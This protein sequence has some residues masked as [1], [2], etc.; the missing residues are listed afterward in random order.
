MVSEP[1]Y[2]FGNHPSMEVRSLEWSS[3]QQRIVPDSVS[4]P[5]L[6]RGAFV[7]GVP[8]PG[9]PEYQASYEEK[10]TEIRSNWKIVTDPESEGD[11]TFEMTIAN[12]DALGNEEGAILRIS[13]HSV[14][15]NPIEAVE[16]ADDAVNNPGRTIIHLL[17]PGHGGST[18]LSNEELVEASEN[19]R[20]LSV[21]P[22]P[23][24]DAFPSIKSIA[25][26]LD[27]IRGN[28][29][30][31]S[32]S[33][34]AAHFT[35]AAMSTLPDVQRA[36][37]INPTNISDIYSQLTEILTLRRD[38][39][40]K[41]GYNP[42]LAAEIA[43]SQKY[44]DLSTDPLAVTQARTEEAVRIMGED[45]A[46]YAAEQR[47]AS[48]H[49]LK[50]RG[51]GDIFK[52]GLDRGSAAVHHTLAALRQNPRAK[53]TYIFPEFSANYADGIEISRFMEAIYDQDDVGHIDMDV[54]GLI[55]P[56]GQFWP[57]YHPMG[58]LALHREAFSR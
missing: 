2:E 46:E 38:Y 11:R 30:G 12:A 39:S 18:G 33:G 7:E 44:A 27:Q 19:G 17:Q 29:T 26:I 45:F 1:N 42:R 54:R 23:D 57:R 49:I 6:D 13:K 10:L 28:I 22:G 24:Y 21:F 34:E 41:Q 37:L 8:E 40:Y 52:K 36:E 50:A 43:K 16:L 32:S 3:G 15:D 25:R 14:A 5:L 31:L 48:A 20:L 35:S 58:R 47:S 53:V 56:V 51:E 55:P 9:S 4:I